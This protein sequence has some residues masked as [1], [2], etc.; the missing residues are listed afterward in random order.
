MRLRRPAWEPSA[1]H[2]PGGFRQHLHVHAELLADEF[3]HRRLPRSRPAVSTIRACRGA[4][5]T[6]TPSLVM[7]ARIVAQCSC[8]ATRSSAMIAITCA[9]AATF[10]VAG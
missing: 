4:A 7:A 3:E 2:D 1:E 5:R 8:I 10:R 6:R 9:I